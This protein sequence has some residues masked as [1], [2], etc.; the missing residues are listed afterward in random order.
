MDT[1]GSL[2]PLQN[3]RAK[4]VGSYATLCE[5]VNGDHHIVIRVCARQDNHTANAK[6]E[7]DES[8]ASVAASANDKERQS[9]QE[10]AKE[11]RHE[12]GCWD[13]KNQKWHSYLHL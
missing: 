5:G 3:G 7:F 11:F 4:Q 13:A 12:L 1:V 2:L 9:S 8:T 10:G 6:A